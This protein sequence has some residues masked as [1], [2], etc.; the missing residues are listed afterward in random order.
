MGDGAIVSTNI[1][2]AGVMQGKYTER[3]LIGIELSLN[4]T[5]SRKRSSP[6]DN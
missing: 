2:E 6:T 1:P 3:E 4:W 5:L